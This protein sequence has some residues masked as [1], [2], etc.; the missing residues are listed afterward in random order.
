[1]IFAVYKDHY[2]KPIATSLF[3]NSTLPMPKP[4]VKLLKFY[5]KEK[6]GRPTSSIKQA[7]K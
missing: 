2:E 3:F 7:K 6:Q 5:I 1:M 4:S